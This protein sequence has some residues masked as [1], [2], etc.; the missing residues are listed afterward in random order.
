MLVEDL[1]HGI[2]WR[3][4]R[5]RRRAWTPDAATM[6]LVVGDVD[7]REPKALTLDTGDHEA[8]LGP[9]VE[10]AVHRER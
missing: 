1:A 5:R 2:T 10:P 6:P 8:E 9:G 3:P 7:E 4:A